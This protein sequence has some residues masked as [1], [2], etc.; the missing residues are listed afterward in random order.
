MNPEIV[1]LCHSALVAN[2]QLSILAAFDAVI[3][4]QLPHHYP[5][6]MV[7]LR[8]RFSPEDAGEKVLRVTVLDID[9]RI[10]GEARAEL[11]LPAELIQPTVTLNM[12]FP[13][14][15]M[16]LK[17]YGEHAIDVAWGDAVYRTH[18]HVAPGRR[19]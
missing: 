19:T 15:G 13:I 11:K 7:A 14:S 1:T 12:A 3:A 5:P 2:N 4:P 8:V 16:E 18:F 6:F 10:L 9:G 17:S